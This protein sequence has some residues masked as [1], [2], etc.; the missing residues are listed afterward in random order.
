[1]GLRSWQEIGNGM[2]TSRR[3]PPNSEGKQKLK[4]PK[5]INTSVPPLACLPFHIPEDP[6]SDRHPLV[7][8]YWWY[9]ERLI[10]GGVK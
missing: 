8:G 10:L 7:W 5:H 6:S 2:C 3:A 1:M 4:R 9:A